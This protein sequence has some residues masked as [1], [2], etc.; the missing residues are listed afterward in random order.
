MLSWAKLVVV[1]SYLAYVLQRFCFSKIGFLFIFLMAGWHSGDFMYLFPLCNIIF[2]LLKPPCESDTT[3]CGA[4][5]LWVY[6]S[7]LLKCSEAKCS[8][9]FTASFIATVR[10]TQTMQPFCTLRIRSQINMHLCC[11]LTCMNHICSVV[12]DFIASGKLIR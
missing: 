3:T 1:A 11:H 4:S 10:A 2:F 8:F 6:Y 7:V 9:T 12:Y 5:L